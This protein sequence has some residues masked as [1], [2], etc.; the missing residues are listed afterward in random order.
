MIAFDID[1]VF[2]DLRALL[3]MKSMNVFDV[4]FDDHLHDDDVRISSLSEKDMI[5]FIIECIK[6]YSREL[7]PYPGTIQF[8]KKFQKLTNEPIQFVTGRSIITQTTQW[9]DY[10]LLNTPY[11]VEFI[12][13]DKKAQWLH[14]N[15]FSIFVEDK[16][17]TANMVAEK[18]DVVFLMNRSWNVGK[19]NW[20][21]IHVD[22]LNEVYDLIKKSTTKSYNKN[23]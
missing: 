2:A 22:D 1:G 15:D 4:L 10:Y 20:N 5:N 21:V 14:D 18:I 17:E 8:F 11:K 3:N 9:L 6:N 12:K 13:W 19:S 16:L 23:L 7:L